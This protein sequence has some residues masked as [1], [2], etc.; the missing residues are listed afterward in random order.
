M[1]AGESQPASASRSNGVRRGRPRSDRAHQAV[2]DATAELLAE[3]D[4]RSVTADAIAERAGVS[5]ATVYKWWPSKVAVA[6][7]VFAARMAADVCIPD[8]GSAHQDFVEQLTAVMTFYTSSAGRTFAQLLA[9][10]QSD[11]T[12]LAEVRDRFLSGRRAQV[13]AIWERG[14]ARGELR[15]E[16]DPEVATDLIYGPAIFRLLTGHGPLTAAV[17]T[18]IVAAAFVGLQ[19]KLD[20]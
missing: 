14:V 9:E 16:V 8:T 7:E 5:K 3:Q 13:R 11:P 6:V 1:R 18:E 4:V 10:G 19:T 12:V 2:L 20:V 17:A 15:G